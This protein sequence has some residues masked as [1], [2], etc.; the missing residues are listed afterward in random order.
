MGGIFEGNTP[1]NDIH[2]DL[3]I[4]NF[5]IKRIKYLIYFYVSD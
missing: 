3:F 5:Q 1:S 2:N 4:V